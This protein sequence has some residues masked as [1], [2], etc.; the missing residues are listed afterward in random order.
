MGI[1][2]EI[3]LGSGGFCQTTE[4]TLRGLDHFAARFTH[5]VSM[6]R[7]RQVVGSGSVTKVRVD[8]DA[9]ALQL[10]EVSIDG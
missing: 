8:D 7:S 2:G 9:Q 6:G 1:D 5:E 4:E 3:E 10:I